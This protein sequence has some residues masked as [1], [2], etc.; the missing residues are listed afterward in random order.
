MAVASQQLLDCIFLSMKDSL[1]IRTLSF[2]W[3]TGSDL[4]LCKGKNREVSSQ[5]ASPLVLLIWNYCNITSANLP[6]SVKPQNGKKLKN[7][8]KSKKGMAK[9]AGQR[10][11]FANRLKGFVLF[12]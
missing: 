11:I 1:I 12:G 5:D 6:I 4:S 10:G 9:Q 3:G 8:C 7:F 2:K